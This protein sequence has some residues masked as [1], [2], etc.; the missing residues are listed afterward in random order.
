MN[1]PAD[2]PSAIREWDE[3]RENIAFLRALRNAT[4]SSANGPLVFQYNP[5]SSNVL[6][7]LRALTASGAVP[8]GGLPSQTGNAGKVLGTDGATASWVDAAETGLVVL[9]YSPATHG[10]F[11]NN[12]GGSGDFTFGWGWM[13]GAAAICTGVKLFCTWTGTKSVKVRI[14]NITT[15]TLIYSE[16]FTGLAS[17]MNTLTLTTPQSLPTPFDIYVVSSYITDGTRTAKLGSVPIS[18]DAPMP[19]TPTHGYIV[20]PQTLIR[21]QYYAASDANPT[22]TGSTDYP[23]TEPVFYF[24]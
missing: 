21:R 4:V 13:F 7:D 10:A 11:Q 3:I 5:G 18:D 16:T 23:T 20:G 9:D 6:L 8:T 12:G 14:Y 15:S 19:N 1:S 24:P 17:G 2:F 22:T